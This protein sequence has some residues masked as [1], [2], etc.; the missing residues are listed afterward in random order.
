VN[1]PIDVTTAVQSQASNAPSSLPLSVSNSQSQTSTTKHSNDRYSD[2]KIH[3]QEDLVQSSES[4]NHARPSTNITKRTVHDVSMI[5]RPLT[6]T[7]SMDRTVNELKINLVSP[8]STKPH[9][10]VSLPLDSQIPQ[11]HTNR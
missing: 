9:E 3:R 5:N 8:Y 6:N 4:L 7:Y 10:R 2:V 1:I 11:Q